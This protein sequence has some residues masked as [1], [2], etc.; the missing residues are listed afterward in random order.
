MEPSSTGEQFNVIIT[1]DPSFDMVEISGCPPKT[2]E[3]QTVPK[4][5]VRTETTTTQANA[6]NKENRKQREKNPKLA[7]AKKQLKW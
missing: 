2:F 5:D 7:C 1:G 6:E 3:L 4:I